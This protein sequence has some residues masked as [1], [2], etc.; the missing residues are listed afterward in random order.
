MRISTN[1]IY[2][3]GVARMSE[4][5]AALLK[6]QQQIAANRR[7]LTPADDPIAAARALDLAQ[8][9]SINA[10]FAT[11]RQYAKDALSLEESMLGSVTGLIQDVQTQTVA[12]GNG[13]YDD[14]QRK[15]IATELRSRLDEL[16]GLANTRDG[17]G[18]YMFAGYQTTT[19]PFASSAAGVQ[20]S[21]DQGQR[22]LQV[23]AARQMAISD[24]GDKVFGNIASYGTFDVAPAA[25]NTGSGAV[26]GFSVYE[27]SSLAASPGT[28]NYDVTFTVPA[29]PDLPTYTINDSSVN[30]VSQGNY[31]SGEAIKF[32]GLQIVVSGAPDD[33]DSMTVSPALPG[34]QSLFTTLSDL[35]NL[36]ET[37][38]ADAASKANLTHGLA[39]ASGTLANA[40]DSVLTVRASVGSRL[41]EIDSLDSAG[42]DRDIQYAASISA[43]VDLDYVKAISD[44]T[45]Q[46]ITLEAA[47]KS[48]VQIS[49]L[50]LFDLM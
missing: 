16:I 12:A 30:P 3:A 24:T 31:V 32:N 15:Y 44:L 43:L 46:K 17:E 41:K 21:G 1:M 8:G 27:A 14:T 25:A 18:N 49:G 26:S 39:V 7:L 37:P 50:S 35:I 6:T 2:E 20:Y 5:Q 9:Q 48:F 45:K 10:Q 33:G 38:A 29:L 23:G 40:L 4:Q 36:L 19:Q 42:E 22:M 34:K 47:Q 28:Y 11:N 13:T